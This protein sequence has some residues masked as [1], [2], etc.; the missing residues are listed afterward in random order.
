MQD[1]TCRRGQLHTFLDRR[2][3]EPK[4]ACSRA[5]TPTGPTC[6]T[7]ASKFAALARMLATTSTF[8]SGVVSRWLSS[9]S[10]KRSI[11]AAFEPAQYCRQGGHAVGRDVKGCVCVC[12]CV[13][14][15]TYAHLC[16]CVLVCV[17]VC[18]CVH[19]CAWCVC[20]YA[21]GRRVVTHEAL[22]AGNR[23]AIL[24]A[25][26]KASSRK[27]RTAESGGWQEHTRA[28]ATVRYS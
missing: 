3:K 16:T 28:N 27:L 14:M 7:E 25:R 1:G 11:T 19:V 6:F 24:P 26:L 9:M 10:W 17:C 13:C 8:S 2:R 20:V 18:V 12:V 23:D 4:A 22:M 15:R 21:C 5:S